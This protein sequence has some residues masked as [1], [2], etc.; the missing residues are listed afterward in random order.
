MDV[1]H[2]V[3]HQ[4]LKMFH[5]I[6]LLQGGIDRLREFVLI[7]QGA[8]SESG[9]RILHDKSITDPRN[10]RH[11]LLGRYLANIFSSATQRN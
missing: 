5:S 8:C 7:N 3:L 6:S 1:F 11:D 10:E 2:N 9:D 4:I